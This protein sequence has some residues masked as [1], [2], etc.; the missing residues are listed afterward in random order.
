MKRT[1]IVI[2]FSAVLIGVVAIGYHF[3]QGHEAPATQEA[4][5]DINAESL[6]IFKLRFNKTSGRLR[7][8]LL[9]SPT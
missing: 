7:I 6:N 8:I 4:L 2:I 5:S 1:S 9:L 3:L